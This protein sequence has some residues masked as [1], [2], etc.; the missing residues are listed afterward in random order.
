M[1]KIIAVLLLISNLSHAL[2][3]QIL[4]GVSFFSPRSQST[5]AARHIVGS[6]PLTHIYD[7]QSWYCT[8]GITPEFTK[9]V[10]ANR[11][12]EALFGTNTLQISGSQIETRGSNDILAD[13]FGLS[14]KFQSTVCVDP[15][16]MNAIF[17]LSFYFGFDEWV[18]GLYFQAFAPAVWTQWK[19]GLDEVVLNSGSD[20]PYPDGY[21]DGD[22][23]AAPLQCFSSAFTGN[24][25]Y[26]QMTTP[27]KYG[28]ICGAQSKGGLSDLIMIL[29]YDIVNRERGRVGLQARLGVPTG[30]RPD[31]EYFFEPIVGNGKHWELGVGVEGKALLW[32][33]G[34][35]QEWSLFSNLYLSHLFKTRQRR[36]FDLCA[37][38]F[39]SRFVL[40]KEFD[41]SAA[42][43]QKLVPAINITSLCCDVAV[44]IQAEFL[45]MFGY[46]HKGFVFD[47][48]YNG[49]IR[50]E[51]KI[52]LRECITEE[53]YALKGIQNV[54][55]VGGF[56]S[57]K[58]QSTATLNGNPFST[59]SAVADTVSP[60]FFG[61]K[62]I[63][64]RSAA[65]PLVVTH[66][67]FVN[68]SH[69]W[70]KSDKDH[71][72]PFLG[73]GS[74]IEFEGV[75]TRNTEKPLHNT[76]SQ[77]GIWLKGGVAFL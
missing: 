65:S 17:E 72:V 15:S 28:K 23:I 64:V 75:N 39:G 5:D 10:R 8:L 30:S 25:T 16:I 76:L 58:T 3:N 74:S 12:A 6:H 61:T 33:Q 27:L 73:G 63:N 9:S 22:A 19:V 56:T 45:A 14:P 44:N 67:I 62:D 41:A 68:F 1:K 24:T 42:Y 38:G 77:W 59:Q 36:S 35:V 20:A 69:S 26:G 51:E 70:K 52:G 50:S 31:S 60:V 57:N 7:A 66:K 18:P 49:W 47:I 37:N 11:I 54:A 53:K 32:E 43:I 46:T 71:I 48:G 21:M 29:G 34:G 2:D 40:A 55:G 4:Q 13:Y